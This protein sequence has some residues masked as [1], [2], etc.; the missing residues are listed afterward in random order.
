MNKTIIMLGVALAWA[1]GGFA[2]TH[3]GVQLWENGPL[4]A[5]TNIGANSPTEMGY[6]FW[7]GDTLGYKWQNEQ[8]VA[9]D[10]SVSGFSFST[11]N[12]PT[13]GKTLAQ[14]QSMGY[15]GP[16]GNLLPA[17]DAA[18]QQWGDDWRVPKA[19]ELKNLIELCTWTWTTSNNVTGYTVKGKGLYSGKS[20]FIPCAYEEAW[21]WSATA[22]SYANASTRI[23]FA[24]THHFCYDPPERHDGWLIRP[25]KSMSAAKAAS[26]VALDTRTGTRVAKTTESIAY[27]TA[28]G[29]ASSGTLKVN[30]TAVS[31]LSSNGTYSWAPDS[32][33]TNYWQLTYVAGTANYSATFKHSGYYAITYVD[34]KGAANT[35]PTQYNIDSNVTFTALANVTGYVFNGWNPASIP[36][37]GFGP[38]TV[39]AQWTP[40]AYSVKFHKNGGTGTMA[41]ESFTYGTAKALTANA[42]TRTGYTFKGWATTAGAT[43]A[44]YTDGQSV[45]N[46]TA[47]ANATVT[48]YA[49]WQANTYYV[50][51][52]ANGGSGTTA[53]LTCTYDQN[54]TLTANAFTRAGHVFLGWMTSANGT[55]VAY[56]NAQA[57]QNLS[58]TSGATVNLYA[59]WTDRWYVDTTSGD[60]TNEG[61]SENEPFKTIQC[62]IDKSVAG[63]TIV[64]A[65]GT[66]A[67][68]TTG[69]EAITIQSVNGAAATIIDGGYPAATN[70]C[71]LV[72]GTANATNTVIRGF[73]IQNGCTIGFTGGKNG[74][75]VSGGTLYDCVVRYNHGGSYGGGVVYSTMYDCIISDNDAMYNGGGARN[76]QLT[77]CLLVNNTCA[78]NGAGASNGMLV[79]CTVISNRAEKAGGGTSGSA[80]TNCVVRDNVALVDGGGAFKGVL[81]GC[82]VSNNVAYQNGGG[83]NGSTITKCV[84]SG[85]AAYQHGG[86]ASGATCYDSEIIANTATSNGGGAINTKLYRCALSDNE[87]GKTSEGYGG[88]T[89]GGELENCLVYSN[90][91]TVGGGGVALSVCRNCTIYGNI[92]GGTWLQGGT[93]FN[94]IIYGNVDLQ[95]NKRENDDRRP[96]FNCCTND[97]HFI[98]AE[99]GDFRLRYDSLCIDAGGNAHNTNTVDFAGNA[100]IDNGTVD[101]G[102]YE[103]SA[104]DDTNFTVQ[105]VNGTGGAIYYEGDSVTVA[106]EDRSP[107]YTFTRWTGDVSVLANANSMTNTFTMP[108]QNLSFA[109]EYDDLQQYLVIDLSGGANAASYP[110]SYLTDIPSG[111]WTDVYKTTKLVMRRIDPGTFTMGSP[112][113]EAGRTTNEAPHQVTVTHPYYIGVFE[114]TQRQWELVMGDR[115][116]AFSNTVCYAARPV[117]NVCFN[118]IRGSDMGTYWPQ[119]NTVDATSFMGRL[120][121]RT[122]RLFDLPTE[123]QWEFACRAGTTTALNSGKELAAPTGVDANMAEVGRYYYNSGAYN[124]TFDYNGS[125]DE[126]G[127]AKVGSYLQNA[128]GLYDMHGNAAELCLDWFNTKNSQGGTDPV[129]PE[130]GTARSVRGCAWDHYSSYCRSAARGFLTSPQAFKEDSRGL[131]PVI[132][133]ANFSMNQVVNLSASDGTDPDGIRLTWTAVPGAEGYRVYRSYSNFTET[134]TVWVTTVTTNTYLWRGAVTNVVGFKICAVVDGKVGKLS[135]GDSGYRSKYQLT[136]ANGTG[137]TNCFANTTVSIVASAAPTGYAFKEWTG[138]AADVALVTSKTSASTKFKMPGRAVTLTATYQPNAYTVKFKAN[139]GTGT[140]ANE[141]FTY[142]VAK[143]LTANAF[144]RTG[145]AFL[146][147]GGSPSSATA[148]YSNQQVVS[149]LTATANGTV[150]LY[151]VWKANT[152]SVK[153]NANGGTGTMANE[154]FTYDVAKALTANAFSRTGYTYQGWATAAAGSKV[155][156]NGQTVS[157]LTAT[158]NGTVN[159]YA[160]WTANPFTVTFNANGGTG[161]A[162]PS[163]GFTY[164]TAQNLSNG[165]Y[166][167]TGYT[168]LGW[169]ADSNATS[170]TYANG[171]SVS[172]LVTSGTLALY[173]VWRPNTYTIRFDP[174][175]ADGAMADMAA[176]YDTA[177]NLTA[178]AF[179]KDGFGFVGWTTGGAPSSATV[180]YTNRQQVV[181]LTANDG[182]V[183]KL[184]AKWTDTWYVNAATGDD[185]N[186]GTSAEQPFKTIQYA[187]D[188]SVDGMAIIVADGTYAPIRTDNLAITIQSV[189]GAAATII[190]GGYPAAT[191]RCVLAGGLAGQTNSVIRGFTIQ[192]GCT[193]GSGGNNGAGVAGGTLYDC[194][195]RSN[196]GGGS[197]GGAVYSTMYNCTISE[198]DTLRSGGGA[199][200]ALLMNCQLVNNS[201]ATNGAGASGGTLINCMVISNRAE[202]AGG[203]TASATL[204]NCIVRDNV[205]MKSGGG[206]YN[207]SL[208]GCVVTNNIANQNGGGILSATVANCFIVGN[209]AQRWGG[210]AHGASCYDCEIVANTATVSGGGASNSKTYRCVLSDNECAVSGEGYGGGAYNGELDNCI[211]Y[212]NR[213]THGRGGGVSLCV[214]RNCTISSNSCRAGEAGTHEWPVNGMPGG[215]NFNCIVYGNT[216][217]SGESVEIDSGMASFNCFTRD[218]HFVDA[219]KG[220][221][222]LLGD[223]PC[224]DM[225]NNRNVSGETDIRGNARIQNGVVDLGAYE[226]TLPTGLGD[227]PVAGT[228]AAVPVE[229]L[230][231]YGYV[232]EDSTPESLQ[233]VMVQVGDN[234]IPLWQSWVAGF[235][236]L[237]PD[238]KLQANITMVDG[239]AVVTWT[240]DLSNAEPKRHYTTMGKTNLTDAAWVIPVNESHRFFKVT[241]TMGEPGLARDVAATA[242]TSAG[243]VSISWSAVDW[244]VGYNIYRST[245][246][247]FSQATL[248]ASTTDTAY[249]DATA[250]PGTWYYY[251]IVSVANGGEWRTSESAAGNRLIGVPQNVVASNGTSADWITVTWNAVEGAVSYRV[252]RATTEFVEDAVEVGTSAGTSWMDLNAVNGV[253]YN[254]WVIAV[255]SSFESE[256]SASDAGYLR[257]AAPVGV[258]ASNGGFADRVKI[259]WSAVEGASHYRVY[260]STAASGSKTPISGWTTALN[261][262]DTTTEPG[263]SYYYFVVAAADG[264]GQ[265]A[266][267]YSAGVVG[268]RKVAAPTGVYATDGTSATEV[269]VSWSAVSGADGYTV[270]RGT[271]SNPDAAEVVS[272]VSSVSFNDTTADPGTLY[273]YWVAATNTVSASE[274]SAVETG[275]R[276]IA[277]PT[278]VTATTTS[279]AAA[280]TI[281]WQPVVGAVYYR[282]YRGTKSGEAYAVDIDTTTETTYADESG[283]ANKTYYYSVKAVGASCDSDFSAFVVGSR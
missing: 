45:S 75:G 157:N 200:N 5:K 198:N 73:T 211:V 281:S 150:N 10:N 250:L 162:M 196:H 56:Q 194:V 87:C 37:G 107:R 36:V 59:K 261:Y 7:W 3:E 249:A 215:T 233:R 89:C 275:F 202:Q 55:T 274:K 236:P 14:L 122:G 99:A 266:S 60:D 51:F 116:S 91:V 100:R 29:G 94:C 251:W 270:Y 175:G 252:L 221:F 276:S 190:D 54:A 125:T 106:A 53:Q 104:S 142:G 195:V 146:G 279:G 40:I 97:P 248:I 159:L 176:T 72:G 191:N 214:S 187:I 205:T 148:S 259:A 63:M 224:I 103:Y 35:N 184:T 271:T 231:T 118:Q 22:V 232:D 254:Y 145:Y 269:T 244:A 264:E 181:N 240:P 278:G 26:A 27:D 101:I 42:F 39:T 156:S 121:E 173:A 132:N 38:K 234:G 70:R 115:P 17:H 57:I 272:S 163:Q 257:L 164:G 180:S 226:F 169:S 201:C 219:A 144:A 41:D 80:L 155:Y 19:S 44:A 216:A 267:G 222:R 186:E 12:C 62:A 86:G 206:S 20:I 283:A 65:D 247:N 127:T 189:N 123:A 113:G 18:A 143:E 212:G 135:A 262:S 58:A 253:T 124:N 85:N 153:F 47:T 15:V 48:L 167:R 74:A 207:G 82:A 140:M 105:V 109:A 21:L 154:S 1:V 31:G 138:A 77:N 30:G 131:R 192:N 225:G 71:V 78:T 242:G 23:C 255:G 183:V 8:W 98:R 204:T 260:R 210:G 130:T 179:T 126:T 178:N 61:A 90:R 64:V 228:D 11:A 102:A 213:A 256:A 83:V 168:F 50:K 52:N 239:E 199:Y 136:V 280:V 277:A 161:A 149:N 193:P 171:A 220:D 66:Y 128:W 151:A 238:S 265:N 133:F 4:W 108:A 241:V 137:S 273:F 33:Q 227:V 120:R 170:A 258:T 2:D 68:I 16:D 110:V 84:I 96:S 160:V 79:N 229:W 208:Y 6:Y 34:T 111:G 147:W 76:A 95:G 237:N 245:V 32:L 182:A 25:V 172:N 46:L 243:D 230:G 49:V 141:S 24:S 119:M 158:A 166:T 165:S 93:N 218:P 203:G 139:K 209:V 177:T 188:K 263:V 88:G 81:H 174:D 223:S 185:T 13:Y 197:G 112:T 9:S 67:P 43:S 246:D 217:T 69:N 117:E 28:W 129:G 134:D 152:Y 282:V 268:S 114:L 92:G 235:D